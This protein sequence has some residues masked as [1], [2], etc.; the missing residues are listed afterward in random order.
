VRAGGG[1]ACRGW[2][3]G[4]RAKLRTDTLDPK[5]VMST[6]EK[7]RVK[8]AERKAKAPEVGGDRVTFTWRPI[9]NLGCLDP[10]AAPVDGWPC[11]CPFFGRS[12]P[13][14][15]L[16][17]LFNQAGS[18]SSASC[19]RQKGLSDQR[20]SREWAGP[21]GKVDRGV[22]PTPAKIKRLGQFAC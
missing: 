16:R 17:A 5:P 6:V 7:S 11:S 4:F 8:A 20:S 2:V 14:G 15:R 3:N 19:C 22:G 1:E 9:G 13:S 21:K 12:E 18:F 10:V